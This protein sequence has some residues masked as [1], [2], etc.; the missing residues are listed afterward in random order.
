[1][2]SIRREIFTIATTRWLLP[3]EVEFIIINQIWETLIT[4]EVPFRPISSF[5]QYLVSLY[6]SFILCLGGSIFFYDKS[7]TPK[8]KN[9]G[10]QYSL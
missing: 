4:I 7:I 5:N 1:M 10:I 8:F 6:F 3:D 2:E 9:D